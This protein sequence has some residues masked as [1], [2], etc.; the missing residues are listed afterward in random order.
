MYT[1]ELP[2]LKKTLIILFGLSISNQPAPYQQ[3]MQNAWW[4]VFWCMFKLRYKWV[5]SKNGC[6]LEG[7]DRYTE[8]SSLKLLR[9][10]GLFC[11]LSEHFWTSQGAAE[12]QNRFK[13][14]AK[15]KGLCYEWLVGNPNIGVSPPQKKRIRR[16]L[17]SCPLTITKAAIFGQLCAS[18]PVPPPFF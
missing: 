13:G 3:Q 18:M 15:L 14:R 6:S 2:E 4:S 16:G 10:I 9:W 17:F 1:V 8:Y 7:T 5:L 11:H 12:T